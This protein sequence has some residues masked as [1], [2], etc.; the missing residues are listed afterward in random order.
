MKPATNTTNENF[1]NQYGLLEPLYPNTRKRIQPNAKT[2]PP[3]IFPAPFTGRLASKSFEIILEQC[4]KLLRKKLRAWFPSH[5]AAGR[6][7]FKD[8]FRYAAKHG[9]MDIEQSER[10]LHYRDTRNAVTHDYG[11]GFSEET[12]KLLPGFISDAKN[13]C[14]PFAGAGGDE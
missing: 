7:A 10:W 2:N 14:K 6:L 4:G 13:N 8:I 11:E 12:L 3:M 1:R 9:L 5:K